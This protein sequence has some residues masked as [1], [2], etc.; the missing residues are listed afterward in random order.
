MDV[1]V[2][3]IN[4]NGR[5]TVMAC[6]ES[7]PPGVETIVV[8]NGSN[9]GSPDEIASRFPS[10]Q[11]IRNR[12]NLGT[13]RAV[14]QAAERAK[15]KRLCFLHDDARLVPGALEAMAGLLDSSADVAAA[16]PE[17]EGGCRMVAR[18]WF[19]RVGPLDERFF[20]GSEWEDWSLRVRRAGGRVAAA[21][22]AKVEHRGGRGGPRA[23]IERARSRLTFLRIH[24][25]ALHAALRVL[26]PFAELARFLVLSLVLF[27]RGVPRR[28]VEAAA[29]FGW[30]VCGCPRKWGL[31]AGAA[32]RYLRL[33]DGWLVTEETLEGFGDFDRH[34]AK[35][36]VVKDLKYKKAL[37]CT[38]ADRTY[39][40]KIY[41]RSGWLRRLKAA[42]LGSRA[43][44]E[45]RMCVGVLERGIP[46][47]PIVGVGERNPGSCV[48]FEKL[49]DWENLQGVLLSGSTPGRRR[50]RLLR[51]YGRFA[52]RVQDQGVWQYDFNPSNV[53]VKDE[54]FKLIDFERMKLRPGALPAAERLHLL[55]K[56]NR[57]EGLSKADRLRFLKGYVAA[58]AEEAGVL[59]VIA[60]EIIRLGGIQKGV[61][62]GHAGERCLQENRDFGPFEA[63]EVGGFYRKPRAGFPEV[64]VEHDAIVA[65]ARAA[66]GDGRYR[67]EAAD[68]AIKAWREANRRAGDGGAAPLAVFRRKGE[69]RG[70]MVYRA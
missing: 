30:H 23:R 51:G 44:H 28:W 42:T 54:S 34:F 4:H 26:L 40:V 53:L 6:L 68:D 22:G 58:H 61:D 8:D 21:P 25:P 56:M 41:K 17:T 49:L 60:R 65:V 10:A 50:R 7:V 38:V 15:G 48:V 64:G 62:A 19:E 37:E 59:G 46:T 9:D 29:L 32:P 14:N 12:A 2:I 67:L 47:A 35:A 45:L 31:S 20:F 3:V 70:S 18:E 63:G 36:R 5:E 33:R 69:R 39:L 24:R 43:D 27:V 16:L 57:L 66:A 55:A 1:S 11:L 52:R 13:A